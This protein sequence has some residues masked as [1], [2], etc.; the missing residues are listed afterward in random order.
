[1]SV[2]HTESC[3]FKSFTVHQYTLLVQRDECFID[4][5][6]VDSSTLSESTKYGQMTDVVKVAVWKTADVGSIP[7]L[8]TKNNLNF[9]DKYITAEYN[10]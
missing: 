4:I 7:T 9:I 8:S 5:E 6:E 1:M 2:L 3:R 10:R